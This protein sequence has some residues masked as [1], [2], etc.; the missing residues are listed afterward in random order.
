VLT[1]AKKRLLG[2]YARGQQNVVDSLTHFSFHGNGILYSC[3][4]YS[5][6]DGITLG[7]YFANKIIVQI[8]VIYASILPDLV[9]GS[10]IRF[11]SITVDYNIDI[12][13]LYNADIT[14]NDSYSRGKYA[15]QL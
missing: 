12:I 11:Y 13:Y 6:I 8:F 4:I 1:E 10:I 14:H 9:K 5:F 7:K 2:I 15:S 3:Y